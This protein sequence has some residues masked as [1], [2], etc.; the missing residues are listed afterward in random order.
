[1]TME[2]TSGLEQVQMQTPLKTAYEAEW[3][4][5]PLPTQTYPAVWALEHTASPHWVAQSCPTY[6]WHKHLSLL[7][8]HGECCCQGLLF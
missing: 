3:C 5:T 2:F 7:S 8:L 6:R 4:G 1:M